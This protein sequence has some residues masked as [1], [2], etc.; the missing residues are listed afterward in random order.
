MLLQNQ[1]S[2]NCPAALDREESFLPQAETPFIRHIPVCPKNV[3]SHPVGI[4]ILT[5]MHHPA[6]Q[7]P[8][9][10]TVFTNPSSVIAPLQHFLEPARKYYC[11]SRRALMYPF[12][13]CWSTCNRLVSPR[14]CLHPTSWHAHT[15]CRETHWHREAGNDS[16]S[17][18]HQNKEALPAS[19]SNM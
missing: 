15:V 5:T 2:T 12:M 8:D 3:T 11:M 16:P 7:K 14:I 9:R 13:P 10:A 1:R 18:A 4:C 19:R 6:P 17:L